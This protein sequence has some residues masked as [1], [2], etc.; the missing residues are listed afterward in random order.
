[1]KELSFLRYIRTNYI[2]F[3]TDKNHLQL[4]E[5]INYAK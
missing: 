4:I 1:M 3:T 5:F 2:Q